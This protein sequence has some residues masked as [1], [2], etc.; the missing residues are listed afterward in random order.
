LS[1]RRGKLVLEEY[2]YGFDK[3]R[4]HDVRSAGKSLTT[5]LLGIAI[6]HGGSVSPGTFVSSLFP[7]YQPYGNPDPRKSKIMVKNLL[8]MTSGLDCDDDSATL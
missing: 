5:T 2:F 3:D 6:D 7:E 8:T 1:P 4:P